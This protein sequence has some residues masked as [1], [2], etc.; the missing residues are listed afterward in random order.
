MDWSDSGA[1]SS[2]HSP[3]LGGCTHAQAVAS[4]FFGT[5]A[6]PRILIERDWRV[7]NLAAY[8]CNAGRFRLAAGGD[9]EAGALSSNVTGSARHGKFE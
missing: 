8:G 1:S 5:A 4:W 6:C 3:T 7:S 2:Q 9:D